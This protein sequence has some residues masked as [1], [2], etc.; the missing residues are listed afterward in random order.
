M[1]LFQC[2][3]CLFG[4]TFDKISLVIPQKYKIGMKKKIYVNKFKIFMVLLMFILCNINR[5]F[6]SVMMQEEESKLVVS[7]WKKPFTIYFTSKY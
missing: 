3:Q 7:I 6:L 1:V 5:F 2:L 4:G